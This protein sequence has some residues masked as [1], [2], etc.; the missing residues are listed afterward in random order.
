L[1]PTFAQTIMMLK[2]EH[3]GIAVRDLALSVPLFEQ[4]LSC[5]CYKTETL[6]AE[7]VNTAFFQQGE[8]KIELLESTDSEGV[9]SKFLDK[10]GE[11]IHHLAF[12]VSDIESEMKRLEAAGFELLNKAPKEGADNKWVCF[13]NPKNTN[14]VLVELCMEKKKNE[15]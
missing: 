14:G 9:I 15:E 7:R 1:N 5:S 8:T 6:E 12:A 3:I 4:L 10:K 13:L 11:G 2:V